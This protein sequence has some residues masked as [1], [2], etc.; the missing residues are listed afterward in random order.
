MRTNVRKLL[1][2]CIMV[3]ML[4][5]LAIPSF[6]SLDD[7]SGHWAENEINKWVEK[8]I[9]KGYGDGTFG[10]ENTITRAEFTALLARIFNFIKSSD[11]VFPDVSDTAW[12][13]ETVSKSVAAGIIKGD[14][15]G[16][17]RPGDPITRQEAAVILYRVFDL[18]VKNKDAAASFVDSGNIPGWSK[19]AISALL[20]NGYI[21][22][23]PDNTFAPTDNMN[24]AE[25]V[26]MIDSIAGDLKNVEGTYT[27][28]IQGNLVVN[29]SG[30]TLK[31][32]KISG[33]LFLAHGIGEGEVI[34]SNVD[35]GGR[36]VVRGGGEN[37][38]ILENTSI[39]GTLLVIKKD[40]KVRIVVKG[41][42]DIP[43]A[44]V[45][46][47]STI[48]EEDLTGLGIGDIEVI[49]LE[50]GDSII[51]DG[52]FESLDVEAPG[53][54]VNLEG[55]SVGA[56]NILE[57]AVDSRVNIN[58]ATVTD[59][60]IAAR[61]EVT[62]N[63]GA[64]LNNLNAN[65]TV[66]V[67]GT[68]TIENAT[69]NAEGVTIEQKP[70][71]ITVAEG[72]TATV[73][74]KPVTSEPET[75]PVVDIPSYPTVSVSAIKVGYSIDNGLNWV[76]T[77]ACTS[78]GTID[79][80]TFD[81]NVQVKDIIVTAVPATGKIK[82]TSLLDSSGNGLQIP[83]ALAEEQELP[84]ASIDKMAKSIIGEN[85]GISLKNLRTLFGS[86]VKITGLLTSDNG[87]SLTV[88]FTLKL[89]DPAE[90]EAKNEWV[91]FTKE[92]STVLAEIKDNKGDTPLQSIGVYTIISDT[93]Y[94]PY[95]VVIKKDEETLGQFICA[96]PDARGNIINAIYGVDYWY[97]Q[98]NGTLEKLKVH[99]NTNNIY[100]LVYR[101]DAEGETPYTLKFNMQ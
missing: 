36:V 44:Q 68:G 67:T 7:I 59:L 70:K 31:D 93:G 54:T 49:E 8:G 76:E 3:T 34:L 13:A 37:S 52:D 22:G 79:I 18:K 62:V 95:K 63:E 71:K 19:D 12:Y 101:T 5:T 40:G 11:K 91:T 6:A 64:T 55:G 21:K 87:A 9:V 92:G 75:P 2:V 77:D 81:D 51:L 84:K 33:D 74:G 57:S 56:V 60:N 41:D 30:I 65:A 42:S 58:S 99:M 53:V 24:R 17:F 1:S 28:D 66:A 47:A 48:V 35:V 46:S 14:D 86:S 39:A 15:T 16:N 80:A 20:E 50:P 4:L 26:K 27:G 98:E 89:G 10:P 82:L 61:S 29:A 94:M 78:G 45:S 25:A 96:D 32:M 43:T 23:R 90:V 83:A 72:V 73:E 100:V 69:I 85:K 97:S 88:S 38:I